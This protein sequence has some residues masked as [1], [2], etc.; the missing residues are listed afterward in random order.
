LQYRANFVYKGNFVKYLRRLAT[1]F[2]LLLCF[3][4]FL[5]FASP[6]VRAG[7]DW[8]PVSPDEL[9]MTSEPKAPGAPAIYLY[10]QVDRNDAESHESVY[11][12]IKIFTDEGRKYA[13]V[14]IPFVRGNGNI[15]NIRARTIRPDGSIVD[16]HGEILQ[17]MIVKAKGVQVLVKT[18][19]MPDVEPGSII[20]Y[21][22]E[23][24]LPE[25]FLYDSTWVIS[26]ELF[27]KRAK[28]SLRP[29]PW[30]PLKASWPH[31]LPD[32]TAPPIEDHHVYRL[33]TQD[34]PAF[35]LEDYMPPEEEFKYRVEFA[36]IRDIER[37]PQKFWNE[38]AKRLY[39]PIGFFINK[40]R[41]MERAV[42]EIVVPSDTPQQKL[43]KIYARCQRLRNLSYEEEKTSQEIG[44]ENLK[45]IET[46][47]DVWKHGYGNSRE[48][49]W[50]FLALVR[51]AGF[52]AAPVMVATRDK[53]FFNGKLMNP[54]QLDVGVVQV[55][56]D[57]NALYL[58]PGVA[59][60]PFGL[61]PWPETH[62][63]GLRMDKD[64]GSW[65]VTNLPESSASG[66]ERSATL[67]LDESGSLEGK[68]MVTFKG[69]SA[70]W[71]R[72]NERDEDDGEKRKFLEDELK[73]YIP[74][75]VQLELTNRPEWSSSS[76]TLVA[77]FHVKIPEWVT[78]A[79]HRSLLAVGLFSGSEK[80][81]F[82]HAARTYPIYYHYAYEDKDD[83]TIRLPSSLQ[84]SGVPKAQEIDGKI[85]NYH[86]DAQS[87]NDSVH[88]SR[89]L[90][91]N[92]LMVDSKYYG[93][94]RDFY[95]R[96]RTA[97]EQQIVLSSNLAA[98][99]N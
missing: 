2:F 33:E 41:A 93:A 60:A 96:V 37:D 13:D 80:H 86:S 36:Y 22:Y 51:A 56:L 69:L 39:W 63:S 9:K 84:V 81:V 28:F 35:Q 57:G 29:N 6:P 70:L 5:F 46:A 92:V 47:E 10:R 27:T 83:V 11:A 15:K 23:R 49:D 8:Q 43:E 4:R 65:I 76:N 30:M 99:Q 67:Q 40:P 3:W 85:C 61:L 91:V 79:G 98:T 53:Y 54:A 45:T 20:E 75:V 1:L 74:S 25:G 7:E 64:G 18:F 55:K 21:R 62:V 59:F 26:E 73:E 50:L 78:G 88:L 89:Q 12:R 34:V 71:R 14:E 17:R 95:Q 58:A 82:D 44:R 32:G 38:E 19:S 68:V 42:A 94:L 16:F 72:T 66:V 24:S 48:I 90:T 87:T 52:D 77:E 97:D 31:G